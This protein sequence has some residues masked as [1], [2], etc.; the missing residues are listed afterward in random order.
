MKYIVIIAS[1]LLGLF[2]VVAPALMK[3][4]VIGLVTSGN[5]D[6][7]C[8]NYYKNKNDY[9]IDP[10]SAYIESSRI[11]PKPTIIKEEYPFNLEPILKDDEYD[12]L[13]EVKVFA[14][15]SMGGYVS[16]TINCPMSENNFSKSNTDKYLLDKYN[17][18]SIIKT[19]EEIRE[20]GDA[21]MG[22]QSY[23]DK[24]NDFYK[25]HCRTKEENCAYL[26][27]LKMN[28]SLPVQFRSLCP[29]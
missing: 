11:L 20:K 6:R 26:K 1:L 14:H 24:I 12:S 8:F 15:N 5:T 22:Y 7:Q 27:S 29:E 19:C 3:D 10:D 2:W 21:K 16:D 25:K 17:R 28:I 23:D 13:I 9:F 18:E 4:K